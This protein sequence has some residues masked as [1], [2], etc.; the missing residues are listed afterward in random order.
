LFGEGLAFVVLGFE[1][2]D[3]ILVLRDRREAAACGEILLYSIETK[4]LRLLR[5]VLYS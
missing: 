3:V 2:I 1:I 5:L 4:Y